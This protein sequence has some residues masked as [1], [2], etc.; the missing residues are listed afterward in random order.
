ME[1]RLGVH[2]C[3][4]LVY[5]LNKRKRWNLFEEAMHDHRASEI[6]VRS[7]LFFFHAHALVENI[8]NILHRA[9]IISGS[10]CRIFRSKRVPIYSAM[11]YGTG[12]FVKYFSSSVTTLW[13]RFLLV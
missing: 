5:S 6:R 1:E 7:N 3:N 4:G 11:L 8:K 10:L 12:L 9:R 2:M 13:S